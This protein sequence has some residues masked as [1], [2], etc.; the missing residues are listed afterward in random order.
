MHTAVQ[1]SLAQRSA[2][3][4]RQA[5]IGPH[6]D[7]AIVVAPIVLSEIATDISRNCN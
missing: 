5:A 1:S 4:N 6:M 2:A 3:A 7:T